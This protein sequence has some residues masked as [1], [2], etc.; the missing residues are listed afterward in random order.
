MVSS[1]ADPGL[2]FLLDSGSRL[3]L[4]CPLTLVLTFTWQ[5]R[6]VQVLPCIFGST[7]STWLYGESST[8]GITKYQLLGS[9]DTAQSPW[10][11]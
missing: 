2:L 7:D 1:Q 9:P 4:V 10:Q 5:Q 3:H 11:H 8:P 6:G